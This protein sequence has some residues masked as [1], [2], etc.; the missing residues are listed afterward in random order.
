MVDIN[1]LTSGTPDQ[2]PWL[3]LVSNSLT[4]NTLI[5]DKANIG[6]VVSSIPLSLGNVQ[7]FAT[8]GP[9]SFTP[10]QIVGGVVGFTYN[11]GGTPTVSVVLPTASAIQAFIDEAKLPAYSFELKIAVNAT[12]VSVAFTLGAGCTYYGGGTLFTVT[13]RDQSSLIFSFVDGACV[14]Y[15]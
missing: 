2:K 9:F 5:A 3:T 13:G 12:G 14:V 6:T 11:P 10:A 7:T 8:A 4:T 1:L 15:G